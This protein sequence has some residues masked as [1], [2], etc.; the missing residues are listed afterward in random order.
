MSNI[1]SDSERLLDEVGFEWFEAAV[2]YT[3]A[4]GDV[5]EP[6]SLADAGL[7]PDEPHFLAFSIRASEN[8][9]RRIHA[10]YQRGEEPALWYDGHVHTLKDFAVPLLVVKICRAVGG[11]IGD[12]TIGETDVCFLAAIPN[13]LRANYERALHLP[14]VQV[15]D[16]YSNLLMRIPA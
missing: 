12:V 1:F 9:V 13:G 11:V 8:Y 3:R 14:E 10:E 5:Y 7:T 4:F 16:T 6:I 2:S 15:H